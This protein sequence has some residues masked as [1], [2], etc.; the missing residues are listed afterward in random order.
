VIRGAWT[1]LLLTIGVPVVTGAEEAV[2]SHVWETHE[3]TLEA[4]GDY[5]NPYVE[6]ICWVQLRGPHF[7]RRVYG[8][9]DGGRTFRVRVVATAPGTWWWR[10]GSNRADGGLNGK[11]GSFQAVEWSDEE[12]EANPNRRGFLRATPNGHALQYADGTPFFFVAD[13]WYA[14][15]SWR[16]PL[17]GVEPPP[18][19]EPGPGIGLEEAVQ[20]RK[21]QGYNGIAVIASFPNWYEDDAGY[22]GYG[23]NIVRDV[24]D[25][26]LRQAW[27]RGGDEEKAESMHADDG[28][29]PFHR[30]GRSPSHPNVMPDFERLNPAYFQALDRKLQYLSDQG[31][32]PFLETVRRDH[33]PSW[34]HYH[35]WPESFARYVQYI[36]ARYDSLNVIFSGVH[37]DWL[38]EDYGLDGPTWNDALSYHWAMFGPPPFGQPVTSLATPGTLTAYGHG[39]DAPWM[40]LHGVGNEYRDHRIYAFLEKHFRL[41]DPY[42]TLNQEAWYPGWYGSKIQGERPPRGSDLD[43]YYARAMAYGSV[44][45]GGLAGHVYG[46]GAFDGSTLPEPPGKRPYIW[47]AMRYASG[48]QMGHLPRFVLSEGAHYQELELAEDDLHPR[49]SP[50]S[51]DEGLTGWAYLMRTPERDFALAYFERGCDPATVSGLRH[52]ASYRARWFDPRE[53][54]WID[55]GSGTLSTDA[56]GRLPL[57]PVPRTEED[58]ALSLVAPE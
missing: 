38:F 24:N 15:G 27:E 5:A 35:V 43:D 16:Y 57:P 54:L 37:F 46:T 25:V 32:V 19:Y 21:R 3:I 39:K 29:I 26:P 8:F 28:S 2:A 49:R 55:A 4:E 51:H 47:E 50:D 36:Y 6:V 52:R 22:N 48:A 53:G 9:W 1:V 45:S 33:G 10:S 18:D 13:T 56:D 7:D 11:G 42:P 34:K 23:G 31:F 14:A 44:L 17:K 41:S 30:P 12:K 20:F 58:W 40:T